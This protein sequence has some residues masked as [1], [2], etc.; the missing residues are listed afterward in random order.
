ML[1]P[2]QNSAHSIS[3]TSRSDC[4]VSSTHARCIQNYKYCYNKKQT[5]NEIKPAISFNDS[6]QTFVYSRVGVVVVVLVVN[7]GKY[8]LQHLGMCTFKR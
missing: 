6:M 8:S 2:T 1:V 5:L 4:H 7:I 3:S